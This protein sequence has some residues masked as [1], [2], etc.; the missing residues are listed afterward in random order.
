[1]AVIAI[2]LFIISMV[3]WFFQQQRRS[4]GEKKIMLSALI[5]FSVAGIGLFM[6]QYLDYKQ[7]L[8]QYMTTGQEYMRSY[9]DIDANEDAD[10]AYYNTKLD[11]ITHHFSMEESDV[12]VK[13]KLKHELEA[14]A[15]FTVKNTNSTTMDEIP[16][17][18]M[19]RP[20]DEGTAILEDLS[21]CPFIQQ[22]FARFLIMMGMQGII[23][24]PFTVYITGTADVMTYLAATYIP[25]LFFGVIG[26]TSTIWLGGKLGS[27]AT[28]TLW[29][30]FIFIDQQIEHISIFRI[31]QH[32]TILF[33]IGTI[34]A[35]SGLL[36][37]T[38]QLKS[39][40]VTQ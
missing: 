10:N 37:S 21:Y 17:A 5:I 33:S 19:F 14:T 36:L 9:K 4:K 26:F 15:V 7:K 30:A 22:M 6:N 38:Y 2:G 16:I 35:M 32:E 23:I 28:G 12:Q 13:L 24:L 11:D 8:T 1:M 3:I 18:Y 29:T 34:I 20:R 27:I 25:L 40:K 39:K 31:A